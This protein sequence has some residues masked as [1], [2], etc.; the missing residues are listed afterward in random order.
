[1]FYTDV[2]YREPKTVKEDP[3]TTLLITTTRK[4]SVPLLYIKVHVPLPL[5]SSTKHAKASL[6]SDTSAASVN[7]EKVHIKYKWFTSI[8]NILLSLYTKINRPFSKMAAENS[9]KSKLKTY[10]S[11]RKNTFTLV[12]LQS[13]SISG[14]ISAEKV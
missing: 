1:M 14:V 4:N 2:E 10:T 3:N 11:T 12:Q 8:H 7:M 5:A 6:F 13:F 9:N